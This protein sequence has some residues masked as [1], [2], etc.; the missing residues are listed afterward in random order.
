MAI[1]A[2][3]GDDHC[4]HLGDK[5]CIHLEEN[6]VSGRRWACGLYRKYG[7]WKIV[8]ALPEYESVRNSLR[9]FN[10]EVDCGDWPRPGEKCHTCGI[11]AD[12]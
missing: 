11:T 10:I 1:C 7:S 5:I 6:T 9:K 12:G 2:G 3:N 8:H 4:C